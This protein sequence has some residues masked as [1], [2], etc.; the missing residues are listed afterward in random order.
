MK[1]MI[2]T[3]GGSGGHVIPAKTI[4]TE[5]LQKKTDVEILYVG[6]KKS[7]ERKIIEEMNI[8]Y[9]PI[10]TGK[11]RR[12]FSIEN[13]TDFFRFI[14]GII[15]SVF[16]LARFRKNSLVFSTGGF[17]A[18]PV[19]IASKLLGIKSIIHEQTAVAGLANKIS[20]KFCDQ[21]L[22]SFEKSKENFPSEKTTL[23]GYPVSKKCFDEPSFPIE[24]KK[25]ASLAGKGEKRILLITGGGNGSKLINDVTKEILG[26][27]KSRYKVFHQVGSHY[28]TEFSKL[29]DENYIPFGFTN[30]L[31]DLI[32][33]SD[34]VVSRA[35]AGTVMELISM[36]KK[37]IFVPLKIAQKNEQF[38][39][40]VEAKD[41]L[42]SEI[43]LED[44]FNAQS[45]LSSVNCFDSS[46]KEKIDNKASD[47]IIEII[48]NEVKA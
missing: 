10:S 9:F 27:L 11:L 25:G 6:G 47:K 22:I 21:V 41:V 14:F 42:G 26:E 1:K 35:G 44:N 13:A 34:V 2:F 38:H 30:S 3:G 32:K 20:S 39:N 24:I 19:V 16:I 18:L 7:I 46:P 45:L 17:V 37:S 40:A 36:G 48:F 28:E 12:Y 8:K 31:V 29:E 5:I 43:I 33:I 23:T 15:Q 4:I